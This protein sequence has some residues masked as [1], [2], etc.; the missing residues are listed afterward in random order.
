MPVCYV[1]VCFCGDGWQGA[2][3]DL[4]V[5]VHEN[6][7]FKKIYGCRWHLDPFKQVY[8]Y[9]TIV[10]HVH[11]YACYTYQGSSEGESEFSTLSP[12]HKEI[13]AYLTLE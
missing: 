2:W 9:V 11:T 13:L 3:V 6:M 7:Y 5:L 10:M 12:C 4:F 1:S 8:E